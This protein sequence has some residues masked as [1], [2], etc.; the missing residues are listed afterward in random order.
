MNHSNLLLRLCGIFIAGV[1]ISSCAHLGLPGGPRAGEVEHVVLV[2]LKEPGNASQRAQLVETTKT[3]AA[4]PG[5]KSVSSG[6]P[7]ASDRKVVD[8][9]FDLGL[10]IR[11]RDQAALAAYE[12][13][14]VH[15]KAVK[16]VLLPVTKKLV[17]YDFT[18]Q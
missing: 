4:I 10:V 8:D 1:M 11:F 12:T 16:E 15:A 14:P 7:L 6:V 3:F 9:S 18:V 13:H 5:V 17:V 2:W